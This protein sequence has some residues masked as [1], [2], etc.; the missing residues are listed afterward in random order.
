MPPRTIKQTATLRCY[1]GRS[2]RNLVTQHATRE[3][4]TPEAA[5]SLSTPS[6]PG[7][8]SFTI[9]VQGYVDLFKTFASTRPAEKFSS[10]ATRCTSH[11]TPRERRDVIFF[12]STYVRSAPLRRTLGEIIARSPHSAVMGDLASC[13]LAWCMLK[14][15]PHLCP[16]GGASILRDTCLIGEGRSVRL[17]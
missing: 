12:G 11:T 13:C 9:G 6:L 15:W 8:S 1:Y 4:I 7:L 3:A 17:V 16:T 14:A 5:H 10:H 2:C